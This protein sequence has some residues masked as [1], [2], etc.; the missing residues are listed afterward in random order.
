MAPQFDYLQAFSRNLG[1]LTEAEQRFLRTRRVAIAGLGGVGGSHLL[2]LTRLGIGRF[3]ISDLD[4]F[5]LVNFNR[6]A[7]AALP[8]LGRPKV[9]VLAELARNINPELDIE[10]FPQGI[11]AGNLDAFLDGVD[12]YLDGLDFFA[13]EARRAVFAA[14]AERGIPAV[15]AAP[16]GMGV[17]L[18]N[19]LPGGMTFEDYFQMEGRSEDEQL[20]RFLLGLSPAMLQMGYLVDDSRVDLAGHKGP[21]TPMAC[22]LCAGAAAT[23]VLKILLKRG[24]VWAAPWGVHF[25]AYGNRLKKTWRPGGNR[26]PLQR[27]GLSVA[28]RRLARKRAARPVEVEKTP[29]DPMERILEQARWAPSGDNTQPWRFEILDHQRLVIHGRDTRDWCVYDLDGRASQI[30]LGAL[31]ETLAIAASGEGLQARFKLQAGAP[32]TAP[33]ILVTLEPQAVPT[34]DPLLPY[35]KVRCTQRRP[36]ATTGL[37]PEQKAALEAAVGEDHRLIWLE[38]PAERRRMARLLFRSAGIRLTIPEAYEVHRRIIDWDAQFSRERI[39]D[40][41]VG[42]DPATLKLMR[43]VM[44]SWK[45]VA[46]M[47]RYLAGT[48]APRLQLDL[49][50]GYRCAAHFLLLGRRPPRTLEQWLAG[51]R[52]VQ[53]LWLTATS[54]GLQFQP[55][56][57]PLIFSRYHHQGISFTGDAR[58]REAAG[59]VAR[60]LALLSGEPQVAEGGLFMGRVGFGPF[61]RA[62]SLRRPLSELLVNHG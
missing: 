61:P 27:L 8:H 22:E 24:K 56:M 36:L 42:L 6:Q 16:L 10:T 34:V 17:A 26:H 14:C 9:E 20:L 52:A 51:G 62:R 31:E 40:Q 12:L 19:F 7:G 46:A 60:E 28:R 23:E 5:E 38:T 55:E 57:T 11:D 3:H 59:R 45:R 41:A 4:R 1:W 37:A 48:L 49:L 13:L 50:P 44:G 47:N 32:E 33:R 30:A 21:S 35:I 54:L 43:W 29:Q 53:R 2:T 39:P 25:D 18:L 58:A 15:T